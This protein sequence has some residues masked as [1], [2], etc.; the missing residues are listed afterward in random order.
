[1]P[2]LRSLNVMRTNTN[3]KIHKCEICDKLFDENWKIMAHMKTHH[4][5]SC[6]QCERTFRNED[7]LKEHI[8]I[9]H[10]KVRL[11]CT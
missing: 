3:A 4:G 1:M 9:S 6:D 11:Y 5:N 7:I 2:K 8:Q 10:E